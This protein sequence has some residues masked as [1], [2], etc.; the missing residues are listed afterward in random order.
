MNLQQGR[1]QCRPAAQIST[2]CPL[3]SL[4]LVLVTGRATTCDSRFGTVCVL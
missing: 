2:Q 4:R 3:M 1:L